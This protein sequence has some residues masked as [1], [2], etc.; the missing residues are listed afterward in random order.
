MEQQDLH[1]APPQVGRK[2]QPQEMGDK[3]QHLEMGGQVTEGQRGHPGLPATRQTEQGFPT[4]GA[5]KGD[6]LTWG[7]GLREGAW[8]E[9]TP[10]L[11]CGE[12][13]AATAVSLSFPSASLA[14]GPQGGWKS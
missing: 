3:T 7:E 12:S 11:R 14:A 6:I 1:E 8:L 2:A 10:Q 4:V 5:G 9:L 13:A